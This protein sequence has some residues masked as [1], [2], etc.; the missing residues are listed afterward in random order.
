VSVI[1]TA[2]TESVEITTATVAAPIQLLDIDDTTRTTDTASAIETFGAALPSVDVSVSSDQSALSGTIALTAGSN[3][4]SRSIDTSTV[5]PSLTAS[6]VATDGS[7]VVEQFEVHTQ[8]SSSSIDIEPITDATTLA[9]LTDIDATPLSSTERTVTGDEATISDSVSSST[10]PTSVAISS[11]DVAI[12]VQPT[13]VPTPASIAA[14]QTV[15]S[16]G[17]VVS[18]SS[19]FIGTPQTVAISTPPIAQS[20]SQAILSTTNETTDTTIVADITEPIALS[21]PASLNTFTRESP[22]KSSSTASA[23]VLGP[24][25]VIAITSSVE[26]QEGVENYTAVPTDD[27]ANNVRL[28]E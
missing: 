27:S 24:D 8:I 19:A 4:A 13:A 1:E 15:S 16:G 14:V 22:S 25:D 28:I 23:R 9:A 21:I 10:L 17:A 20:T 3:E 18:S 26:Y 6:L 11:E 5:T 2:S 7:V 12:R